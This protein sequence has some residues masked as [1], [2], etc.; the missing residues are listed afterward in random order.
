M[1]YNIVAK[2]IKDINFKIPDAKSYFLIEK[3]IS[4]Y[5]INFDIKSRKIKD[6]ILE[7]D[8]NLKLLSN[9]SSENE[10]KVSILFSTLISIKNNQTDKNILEKIILVD[11]PT[12]IYPDIRNI[13]IFLF[14]KSGFKKINID[15]TVDFLSLYRKT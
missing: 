15:E 13:V 4:N 7:I 3:N 8:T 11:V 9:E 12:S 6:N 14:E 10:I 2:Y 1:S 5:K